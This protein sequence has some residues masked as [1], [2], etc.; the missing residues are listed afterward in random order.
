VLIYFILPI[1]CNGGGISYVSSWGKAKRFL[2]P[3][4]YKNPSLVCG[5]GSPG[6]L[7]LSFV[8]VIH[9]LSFPSPFWCCCWSPHAFIHLIC[10]LFILSHG[11]CTPFIPS[12]THLSSF[13]CLG[14]GKEDELLKNNHGF[15]GCRDCWCNPTMI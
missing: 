2:I 12:L 10:S 7:I 5:R 8:L 6:W 4:N 3:T 13:S 14:L 9:S 1:L 11:V 15:V